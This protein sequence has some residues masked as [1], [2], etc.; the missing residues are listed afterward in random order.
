MKKYDIFDRTQSVSV[1]SPE[2]IEC[3]GL[4]SWNRVSVGNR[5]VHLYSYYSSK[6]NEDP[7]EAVETALG[8]AKYSNEV[9]WARALPIQHSF[10]T[11]QH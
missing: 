11:G 10:W 2:C 3:K 9:T 1:M 7:C 6:H 5:M 8:G 4:Y